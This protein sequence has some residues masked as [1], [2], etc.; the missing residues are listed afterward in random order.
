MSTGL[1]EDIFEFVDKP[2]DLRNNSISLTK[3]NR[4]VFYGTDSLS[5]LALKIW[6]LIHQSLKDETELSQLTY[7]NSKLKSKHGLTANAHAGCVNSI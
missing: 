1:I 6:E 4:T 2:Y 3:R 7:P 5:S